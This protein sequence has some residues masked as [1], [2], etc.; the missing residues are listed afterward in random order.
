M[1]RSTA[2]QKRESSFRRPAGANEDGLPT[3]R[4]LIPWREME[5]KL[6]ERLAAKAAAGE[7]SGEVEKPPAEPEEKSPSAP[8]DSGVQA[9]IADEPPSGPLTYT[10]YSVADLEA[11]HARTARQMQML[12]TPST[13]SRWP[14]VA[15]NALAIG[16]AW[17]QW[18]RFPKPRPR[19]LDM[20][21]QPFEAFWTELKLA[22]KE[23]PW[24]KI[25]VYAGAAV[26]SLVLLMFIVLT[27]AELTDD[28]KP[29]KHATSTAAS[30]PSTAAHVV[31][32]PKATIDP[33]PA[34]PAA[35]V[36]EMD[37]APAAKAAKRSK[38]NPK[39]KN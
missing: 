13:P 14:E 12:A 24:R 8:P 9:S 29:S 23:L 2:S 6:A 38:P 1:A 33:V 15:R 37:D 30:A 16:S 26:G 25:G 39:K 17:W 10:V 18:T 21:R 5:R 20:C 28:L 22:L 7:L 19:V 11:R 3:V 32:A 35:D 36:I 4:N 31:V 27:A 34:P